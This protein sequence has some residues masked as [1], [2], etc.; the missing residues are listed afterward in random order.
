MSGMEKNRGFFNLLASYFLDM[1]GINT[2]FRYAADTTRMGLL[3]HDLDPL[4]GRP[5]LRDTTGHQLYGG[6]SG[7]TININVSENVN[8]GL[9][10][11]TGWSN[12]EPSDFPTLVSVND[13]GVSRDDRAA[14]MLKCST[15]LDPSPMVGE[16]G[17][18]IGGRQQEPGGIVNVQCQWGLDPRA[19]RFH[20]ASARVAVRPAGLEFIPGAPGWEDYLHRDFSRLLG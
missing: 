2:L 11:R 20:P 3:G 4:A 14:V 8:E 12:L 15:S 18:Y 13:R 5:W 9:K 16:V 19:G 6:P 1:E 17:A 10:R 7:F